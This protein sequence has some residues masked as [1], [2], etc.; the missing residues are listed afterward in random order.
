M[1][2]LNSRDPPV[3]ATC[4]PRTRRKPQA[5]LI[6]KL[7]GQ[8]AEFPRPAYTRHALGFSPRGTC[9]GSWYG[10]GGSFPASFSLAPGIGRTAL[11]GRPF[12]LSPGS[13]HYGTPQAYTVRRRDGAAR[14]TPK[15]RTLGLASPRSVPPRHR[16]INRFPFRPTRLR[17]A[18]GPAN[19]WL[20]TIAREPWP[21]RRRG[22]S[23]LFAVTTTGICTPGR[24]TGPH[25]P[26]SAQPGRPPTKSQPNGCVPGSRQLA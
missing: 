14:P 9:V 23:P 5:P 8:F 4:G 25:G 10:R 13:R 17:S 1:F 19:P 7:R 20:T 16:N 21:L 26:A 11:N 3:T 12:L 15:R 6:P 2:L 18:L 22:F 24:S